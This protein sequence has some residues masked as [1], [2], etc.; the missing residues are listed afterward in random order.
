MAI[1]TEKSLFYLQPGERRSCVGCHEPV[2]A[3]PDMATV[4][5]M[6]RMKPMDLEPA[7][8]PQYRGGLSFART[9]QPVLDRY[10]IK[11]HGLE[12]KEKNVDLTYARKGR[13]AYPQSLVEIVNRGKHQIGDKKYS[14][15][16]YEGTDVTYNISHP[17]KFFAYENKVSHMLVNGTKKHP[18]LAKTDRESYMRIIEW[19]DLNGQC[20]GDLFPNR[21]E[22]RKFDAGGLKALRAYIKELFGDKIAAQPEATLVNVAQPDESRIL[23]MPLPTAAGG[24]GQ[25]KGFKSKSDPAFRK[26]VKLVDAAIKRD[27]NENINGWEPTLKMGAAEKWVTQARDGYLK[28]LAKDAAAQ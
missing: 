27:P 2:G 24:W 1:L 14:E 7:A 18:K 16:K 4:S 15:R 3:A 28:K 17:R 13:G 20:Y 6:S 9:V 19:L 26:M 5:K 21:I 25:I 10:C 23:L 11:C 12:K 22:D 8:G